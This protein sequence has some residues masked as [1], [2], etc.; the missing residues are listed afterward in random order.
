MYKSSH[1]CRYS[2]TDL[3]YKFNM[4][5]ARVRGEYE[6]PQYFT[7]YAHTTGEFFNGYGLGARSDRVNVHPSNKDIPPLPAGMAP[8]RLYPIG[9]VIP[10]TPYS[11]K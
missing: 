2:K 4:T 11:G 8:A 7:R 5:H 3:E 10:A 6:L 9:G 1:T